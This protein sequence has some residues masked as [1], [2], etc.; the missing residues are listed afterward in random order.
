MATLT[1]LICCGNAVD[2]IAAACRSVE[3]ADELLIVDSGSTDGTAQIAK[4]Y[5]DKYVVEPW[6]GYTGQKEFAVTL[7]KNDW[8]LILDADEEVSKKL[9]GELIELS[10][11]DL[12]KYD[13]GMIRRQ[14]YVMGRHVRAWSPDWMSRLMHRGRIRWVEHALHDQREATSPDRVMWLKGWLEHKRVSR[15]GFNDYFGGKRMDERLISIA[16][17]MH[18]RGR[19]CS[20][21]DLIVRPRM[22]FWKM[23]LV[24]RGFMDGKFG[25]LIAQKA[26]VSTQLKYAALWAV[27]HEERSGIKKG[28]SPDARH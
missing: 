4:H 17:Q 18:A 10:D 2:T 11:R 23:Y 16:R 28:A 27:E 7:A 14:N 9:A 6:R 13:M 22:A 24:K 3:W 15:S 25:L 12:D 1:V 5:A 20:W 21:F 8:I 19:R 26:A